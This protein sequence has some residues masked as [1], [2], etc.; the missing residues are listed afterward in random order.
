MLL[1]E[2]KQLNKHLNR[3][4]NDSLL[5]F[6]RYFEH[7]ADGKNIQLFSSSKKRKRLVEDLCCYMLF[8]VAHRVRFRSGSEFGLW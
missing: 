8:M 6:S 5:F 1:G 2:S 3:S 7:E 4:L